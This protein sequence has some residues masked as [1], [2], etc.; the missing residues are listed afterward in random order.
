MPF[1]LRRRR[2]GPRQMLARANRLFDR[3]KFADAAPI[4]D[5]LAEGAAQR[6]M[7]NR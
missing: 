6:G 5:R 7:L 2:P 1:P 3:G 4:F